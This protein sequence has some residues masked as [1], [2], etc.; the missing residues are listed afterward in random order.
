MC[1]TFGLTLEQAHAG[2][3]PSGVCITMFTRARLPGLAQI[4]SEWH[5]KN[6][7]MNRGETKP[8]Q[9]KL[10]LLNKPG[11]PFTHSSDQFA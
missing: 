6:A 9:T 1:V 3:D 8:F 7:C 11:Y 4:S 5:A 10:A 2:K